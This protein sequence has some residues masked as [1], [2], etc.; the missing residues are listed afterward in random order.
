MAESTSS[1]AS[2]H[3]QDRTDLLVP[4]PKS[5]ARSMHNQNGIYYDVEYENNPEPIYGSK[6][7]PLS[8]YT[9][10][11]GPPFYRT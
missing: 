3:V 10:S 11:R 8:T 6:G 2:S 5:R 7:I 4:R 1:E 9:V